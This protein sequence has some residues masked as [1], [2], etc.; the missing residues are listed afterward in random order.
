MTADPYGDVPAWAWLLAV[1]LA[2]V[3]MTAYAAT[4]PLRAAW[5]RWG[6]A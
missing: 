1:A 5:R 6:P 3:C 4:W 2:F